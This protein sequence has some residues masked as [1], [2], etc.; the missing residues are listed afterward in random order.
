MEKTDKGVSVTCNLFYKNLHESF[1]TESFTV[2]L[3]RGPSGSCAYLFDVI[4]QAWKN[5]SMGRGNNYIESEVYGMNCDFPAYREADIRVVPISRSAFMP[6]ADALLLAIQRN[7]QRLA[8]LRKTL[9]DFAA[10]SNGP[11]R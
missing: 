1:V 9:R 4:Q 6:L 5:R 8:P 10:Q 11:R 2:E 7:R 3:E